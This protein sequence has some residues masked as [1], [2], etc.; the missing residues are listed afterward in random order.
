MDL[1]RDEIDEL[2][3]KLSSYNLMDIAKNVNILDKEEKN[4]R[5]LL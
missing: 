2:L 3:L 4:N 1:I 5:T